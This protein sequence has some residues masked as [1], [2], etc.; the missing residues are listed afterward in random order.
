MDLP[1]LPHRFAEQVLDMELRLERDLSA[2][3]VNKLMQLYSVSPIQTAVEYYE[4]INDNKYLTYQTRL[5]NLLSRPEVLSTLSS[6]PKPQKLPQSKPQL[7]PRPPIPQ[8]Q[9]PVAELLNTQ[10]QQ[11][12]VSRLQV[13]QNLRSQ[14]QTLESR[15][16]ARRASAGPRRRPQDESD[17]SGGR[18]S[19][20][21][22]MAEYDKE[23]E[24]LMER[25]VTEKLTRTA[26]VR[27][28]YQT[29]M[30]E[31]KRLGCDA[32]TLGRMQTQL[33][34]NMELEIRHTTEALEQKKTLELTAL[35]KRLLV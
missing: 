14:K 32:E 26:D 23:F 3:N 2:I 5:K 30:E 11:A 22:L 15:L 17:K 8:P 27:R 12:R 29:Q 24:N 21:L 6:P 33:Q 1:R 34:A 16:K 19:K 35:K 18:P 10:D 9:L 31:T 25:H 7:A 4:S 28:H 20:A 13:S